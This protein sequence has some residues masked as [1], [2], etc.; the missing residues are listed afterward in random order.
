MN[1]EPWPRGG[2]PPLASVAIDQGQQAI[3]QHDDAARFR[4]RMPS[5]LRAPI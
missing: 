4:D 5:Y 2:R 1:A 3:S